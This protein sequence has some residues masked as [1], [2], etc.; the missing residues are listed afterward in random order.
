[1]WL[2]N[3]REAF[4]LKYGVIKQ[5]RVQKKSQVVLFFTQYAFLVFL[6]C[7]ARY[8]SCGFF[9]SRTEPHRIPP[10]SFTHTQ[11]KTHR[12]APYDSKETKLATSKRG[13]VS[14]YD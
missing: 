4:R 6:R 12:T 2:R 1:M 11:K 14:I 8:L 5:V 13:G 3:M 7:G 9:F 10:H